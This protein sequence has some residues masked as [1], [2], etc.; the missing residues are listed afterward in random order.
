MFIYF[1]TYFSGIGWLLVRLPAQQLIQTVYSNVKKRSD[2]VIQV[3]HR[4]A[5]IGI[6]SGNVVHSNVVRSMDISGIHQ[7][8]GHVPLQWFS[9]PFVWI[10]QLYQDLQWW[11]CLSIPFPVDG[12]RHG[13]VVHKQKCCI[14][15]FQDM[16][17]SV[18][19]H[20][21]VFE[22]WTLLPITEHPT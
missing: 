1:K 8:F 3:Q 7:L 17:G 4:L 12:C 15:T 16:F 14:H 2:V 22:Y 21:K 5:W 13:N 18:G 6:N 20:T 19:G 9:G 10:L 11:N